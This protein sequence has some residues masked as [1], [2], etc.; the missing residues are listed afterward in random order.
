MVGGTKT[1]LGRSRAIIK[2]GLNNRRKRLFSV[3]TIVV[4]VS[5]STFALLT[6]TVPNTSASSIILSHDAGNLDFKVDNHTTLNRYVSYYGIQQSDTALSSNDYS[7]FFFDQSNYDHRPNKH[8]NIATGTDNGEF[9]TTASD[10]PLSFQEDG[11]LDKSYGTFT[12]VADI[13][14][15][16]NDIRVFQTAWSMQ[17]EDWGIV[18]WSI[19]NLLD[20]DLTEVRFGLKF[21]ACIGGDNGDDTD[22]WDSTEKVY[23]LTDAGTSTFIGFASVEIGT[24]I[25]LYKGDDQWS[26][27]LDKHIYSAISGSSGTYGTQGEIGSVIG[28]T[29]DEVANMGLT[30]PANESITRAM[31]IAGGHSYPELLSAIDNARK[32]SLSQI[33]M[34]TEIADEG[35]PRVEIYNDGTNPIDL[36]NFKL[37][38]DDGA[39]YWGAGPGWNVTSIP[40]GG[41]SVWPIT[42]PD[43]FDNSE[44]DTISLW[45]VSSGTKYGE[46]T[47]G[48]EGIAPDPINNLSVGSIS[49][50][51]TDVGYLYADW[52]H[53]LAGMSFGAQNTA[54]LPVDNEPKVVLNEVMF[55]P[56]AP[57][58]GYVEI[59]YIGDSTINIHNYFLVCDDVVQLIDSLELDIYDPFTFLQQQDIPKFFANMTSGS[60]N[61]YLYDNFGVLLDMVGWN[62]AHQLNKTV[63]R[64]PNGDGTYRGYNDVTSE[65]AGWVFDQ[66]I[67]IPLV[68]VSPTG[69]YLY[70]DKGSEL[71]FYLT[72]E[73]KQSMADIFRIQCTSLNGWQVEIYLGDMKTRISDSDGDGIPT[74]YI[75]PGEELNITVKVTIPTA[76]DFDNHDNITITVVSDTNPAISSYTILSARLYPC[77]NVGKS[78]S[79]GKINVLGTGYDEMATI[80]LNV[81]GSGYPV[82]THIPQDVI[83]VVDVSGSMSQATIDLTK[84]ALT[85]YVDQMNPPDR[86]AVLYFDSPQYNGIVLMNPL[87]DDYNQLRNDIQNIPSPLG[88]TYMGEALQMAID[89]LIN[90]GNRSHIW[91]I[92]L[93]TDGNPNGDVDP[94]DMVPIAAENGIIIFTIGLE[95]GPDMEP[96]NQYLLEDEIAKPTGGEYFYAEKPEDLDPIYQLIANRLSNIAGRDADPQDENPMIVDVLPPGI[97]FVPGSFSRLPSN[98][99]VNE[100]GYTFIEWNLSMISLG[101]NWICT[102]DIISN[103]TGYVHTNN[104]TNSRVHYTNW[105]DEQVTILFPETKVFVVTCEPLPPSLFIEVVDDSGDPDGKGNNIRLSWTPPPTPNTAYYLIYRSTSQTGFDFSSPWINTY[106]DLDPWGGGPNPTRT[107]WNFTDD[108]SD[109]APEEYYYVIRTVNIDNEASDTSRTV[110]KYTTIFQPGTSTFSLPLEPLQIRDTDFYTTDMGANYIKWMDP[111][112]HNWRKYGDGCVNNSQMAV[113]KGFE[114]NFTALAKYTFTGMPAAM[115]LY[116]DVTSGFDATPGGDAD[117]LRASVESTSRTVTLSWAQPA[118][119]GL[120]DQYYVFRSTK[121]NGFWGILGGDFELLATL[122]FGTTSHL[123]I[124]NA[125]SGT[126]YYYMIVPFNSTTGEMGV[127]SYSI[128]VWTASYLGQYDTFALPLKPRSYRTADWYCDNI[129]NTVGINYF[130]EL[131]Q[132]WSWHSTRMPANAFDPTLDR[133]QGYQISTSAATKFSFV[134]T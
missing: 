63:T 16:V 92:I 133:G 52:V 59:M 42:A 112:A 23:Y 109:T 86:G 40:G 104:V 105:N 131:Y 103:T 132:I 117:S 68:N 95:P 101:E 21:Y 66:A 39:T 62:T 2:S 58:Y 74:I 130:D 53:S 113:G 76:I 37:S 85:N 19:Q 107:S 125:I 126:E 13:K 30:I 50:V 96:I 35:K 99:Y 60:D 72:V 48:Q 106:S 26:L 65:A 69:Q 120:S 15:Q 89:E 55:N 56:V 98:I 10:T 80:T 121:R 25:N 124:G 108:A 49:R 11:I 28:W 51:Y 134:G 57:G 118:N 115:I 67:T 7:Y 73:N 36:T 46:V 27:Y 33:L 41:Y 24:P 1:V 64:V 127:S 100:T 78:V 29:D 97:D 4:I 111:G 3:C 17:G 61:V 94:R 6:W 8:G 110:G 82:Y 123:D 116:D 22:H 81:T 91:V 31:I 20:T 38:V 47:F 18:Q 45:D 77:L 114:V 5:S 44:G 32:F 12:K 83:F 84:V 93:L 129:E 43:A 128:G 87:T 122:P 79:P 54:T 90:N 70:G 88:W 9:E 102:F 75:R 71:R 119:I 34:I 14:G